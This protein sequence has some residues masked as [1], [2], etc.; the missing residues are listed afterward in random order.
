MSQP[1]RNRPPRKRPPPKRL[2]APGSLPVL[3]V[4][5]QLPDKL[6]LAQ[7]WGPELIRRLQQ[8]KPHER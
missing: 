3:T 2:Q 1:V 5:G 4:S 8:G 7:W 6:P